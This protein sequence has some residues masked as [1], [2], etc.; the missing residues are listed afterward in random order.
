MKKTG[1]NGYIYDFSVDYNSIDIDPIKDIQ[2]KSLSCFDDK[3]F[4]L[5]DEIHTLVVM[6]MK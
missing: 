1:C 5:S 4:I 6:Y 2:K 3:R